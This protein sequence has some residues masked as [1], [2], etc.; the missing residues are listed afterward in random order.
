MKFWLEEILTKHLSVLLLT[1]YSASKSLISYDL[2]S[3]LSSRKVSF[4]KCNNPI[5]MQYNL[6]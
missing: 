5:N 6:E 4:I 3:V 2:I 1:N